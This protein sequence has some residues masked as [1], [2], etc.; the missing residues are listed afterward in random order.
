MKRI[1]PILVMLMAITLTACFNFANADK[2]IF[3][4]FQDQA[5]DNLE[6]DHV[7]DDGICGATNMS[8]EY[9]QYEAVFG[10]DVH[11]GGND[12]YYTM[13]SHNANIKEGHVDITYNSSG[14]EMDLGTIQKD[15]TEFININDITDEL[16]SDKGLYTL[17]IEGDETHYACILLYYNGEN[18]KT[19]RH[20]DNPEN[21]KDSWDKLI[22][23]LDPEKCKD[24]WV[25][26]ESN[27]ITYP[28]SGYD[29][30]C[31]HVEEWC[32]LADKIV[33]NENWSDDAKV[34]AFASYM[35]DNYAY[36]DYRYDIL[37]N[38]SRAHHDNVFN[39]DNYWLYYN[40]VGNCLDFVNAMTIMC[41]HYGIPCT[42]VENREHTV[43]AVWL[44]GEWVAIDISRLCYRHCH[45]KDT[46]P[47]KW[48]EERYGSYN[49]Y[50]G[51]YQS[52]MRT[53]NQSISTPELL[54]YDKSGINPM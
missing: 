9:I 19:C 21:D 44:H 32:D 8:N 20:S 14:K 18:V 13:Y 36:D 5:A 3:G 26:D 31:V 4:G 25:G 1:V 28:T 17:N 48:T 34:Y 6:I 47:E 37:K 50:F 43:N 41:R 15:E 27:P 24:M 29:N 12:I 22:K 42:S 7:S 46:D 53:Y 11:C 51:Y 52:E 30:R 16:S 35:A 40:K 49:D 45:Y 54:Q 10:L 39:D 33:V 38:T 23:N 2:S